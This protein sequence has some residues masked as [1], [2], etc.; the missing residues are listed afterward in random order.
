[1]LD[2]LQTAGSA[3]VTAAGKKKILL[4]LILTIF[5]EDEEKRIV[6]AR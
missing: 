2:M 4:K 1:M 5:N 6:S 3:R